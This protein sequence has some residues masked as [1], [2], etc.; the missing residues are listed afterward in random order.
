MHGV[1][2]SSSCAAKPGRPCFPLLTETCTTLSASAAPSLLR[3]SLLPS[4]CLWTGGIFTLSAWTS[5]G[6]LGPL[7]TPL[8]AAICGG[9]A[10]ARPHQLCVLAVCG[11]WPLCGLGFT[12][13]S[14]P[15]VTDTQR[16][17]GGFELPSGAL[18]LG[19]PGSQPALQPCPCRP[20]LAAACAYSS[21]W[22][23]PWEWCQ[24]LSPGA[25][26]SRAAP[27]TPSGCCRWGRGA[28]ATA[29]PVGVQAPPSSHLAVRKP[30]AVRAR[31]EW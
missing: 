24:E 30:P 4:Q 31:R 14:T 15:K 1:P 23:V 12:S 16:D 8:A 17:P 6:A 28:G 13:P 22:D 10:A 3:G 11:F 29:G 9:T 7:V 19:S 26:H 5:Q 18:V 25:G 21:G 20:C 27:Q 2:G